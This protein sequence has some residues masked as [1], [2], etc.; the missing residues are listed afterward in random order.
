MI[1]LHTPV[2]AGPS[3]EPGSVIGRNG[4]G[5]VYMV[6]FSDGRV[7]AVEAGE[8]EVAVVIRMPA[9]SRLVEGG[10]G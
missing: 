10:F 7:R 5:S 8:V 6:R 1:A 9:R 3:R 4:C 2:L